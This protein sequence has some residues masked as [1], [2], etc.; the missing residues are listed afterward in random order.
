M[1]TQYFFLHFP[2]NLLTTHTT[3]YLENNWNNNRSSSEGGCRKVEKFCP[4]TQHHSCKNIWEMN[5]IIRANCRGGDFDVWWVGGARR[6]NLCIGPAIDED[7]DDDEKSGGP[8]VASDKIC[9]ADFSGHKRGVPIFQ[10]GSWMCNFLHFQMAARGCVNILREGALGH[11]HLVRVLN[12][13]N[14]VGMLWVD[15]WN[16]VGGRFREFREYF[17]RFN[18]MHWI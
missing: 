14:L 7:D 6:L 9:N 15:N 2:L 12:W 10:K 4:T 3:I 13:H 1:P 5:S 17:V 11:W 18:A 8:K 16:C